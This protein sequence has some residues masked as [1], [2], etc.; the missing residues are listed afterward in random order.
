VSDA[1][2]HRVLG[3]GGVFVRARDPEALAGWYRDHLGFDVQG[4]DGASMAMFPFAEHE[5]GY[6]LWSAFPEDTELFAAAQPVMLNWR[7]AD[8]DALL[9]QLRADG[10]EVEERVERSEYGAFGWCRDAEGNRVELWQPPAETPV[11]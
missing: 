4:F 6:Q 10:V 9:S 5:P 7:V 1:A 8:L 2:R 11:G 3:L